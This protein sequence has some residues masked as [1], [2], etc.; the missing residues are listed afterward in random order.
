[1][2]WEWRKSWKL[3]NVVPESQLYTA[4]KNTSH[5]S[6]ETLPP[7]WVLPL[8]YVLSLIKHLSITKISHKRK[9]TNL[10]INQTI[11]MSLWKPS[12]V[13]E[14][15]AY[16]YIETCNKPEPSLQAT[17][18]ESPTF[19][20]TNLSPIRTAVDAVEPA[21]FCWPFSSLR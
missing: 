1:M 9:I 10:A 7:L 6:T 13:C 8:S 3:Q 5:K 18:L 14:N 4:Q 15:F 21:S 20:T 17:T 11:Y 16:N 19:A 2:I 12:R